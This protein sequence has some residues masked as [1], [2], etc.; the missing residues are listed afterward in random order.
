M[1]WLQIVLLVLKLLKQA[2]QS[3]SSEEFAALVTSNNDL[4]AGPLSANGAILKWLWENRQEIL[5]FIMTLIN[6]PSNVPL[7]ASSAESEEVAEI[8]ALVEE[9]KN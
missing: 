4:M 5:D 9:L 7:G 8:Q 1:P 3:Q 6:S 2:K